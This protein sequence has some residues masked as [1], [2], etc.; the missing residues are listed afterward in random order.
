M[1][2]HDT[3]E[4]GDLQAAV[5]SLRVRHPAAPL[6]LAS[7]LVPLVALSAQT[8]VKAARLLLVAPPAVI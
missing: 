5:D 4:T 7:L 3:G 1:F 6:W 8:P 2:D